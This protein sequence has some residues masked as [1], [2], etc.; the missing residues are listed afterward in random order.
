MKYRPENKDIIEKKIIEK[1]AKNIIESM[2]KR[3]Q[4]ERDDLNDLLG[5]LS[6]YWGAPLI[7]EEDPESDEENDI[8]SNN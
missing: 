1:R 6:P 4:K 5:D 8:I 3:W 2:K 7:G